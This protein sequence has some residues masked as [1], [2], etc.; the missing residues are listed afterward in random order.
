MRL[1]LVEDDELIAE[2]LVNALSDQRYVVDV[3][4][5]GQEGREL[6]EIFA[7]DLLLLDVMLPKL[8]GITLCQQLRSQGNRIPII[9]LTALD[10]STDKVMGLDAGADDYVV[11]P[12]DL[13]ELLARIRALLRR[14]SS[15]LPPV[16]EW[17]NLHLDPSN[18]EVTY[19]GR[20]LNL[21]PKEYS[22]L[23]LF[24]RN[25]RRVYSQSAILEQLWSYEEL[26]EE[27]TVRAHIKGLRQKLKAVGAPADLIE[28]VY[29]LG[30][31]LKLPSSSETTPVSATE[32]SRTQQQ[33]MVEVQK[34]WERCVLKFSNRVAVLEQATTALLQGT[35]ADELRHKA[36][37]EAHKLAGSLGMFGF[38]GSRLAREIEQM[39]QARM[40][41]GQDQAL[42]MSEL[43]VALRRDLQRT[44]STPVF[45]PGSVDERKKLLVVDD[46]RSCAELLLMEAD[47]LGMRVY[48]A[49]D[50]SQARD[51][52]N[53]DRPHVV[54]LKLSSFGSIEDS[55]KLLAELNTCTP[56]VP[57]VVLTAQDSL[58]NRVK[59]ARLGGRG[60]LHKSLPP[61]QL[62]EAVIQVLKR[63]HTESAKVMAVDDDPQVLVTLVN[64]L[65]PWGL[66]VRTLDDPRRFWETL[67]ESAPDLLVLDVEMAHLSGIELCQ[68]VRNDPRWSRLPVLFLSVHTDADT[69]NR[70][71]A[72]GADD[73]VV[74]PIVG[75]ELV[76]RIFNRLERSRLLRNMAEVDALTGV[77]NRRKL[78]QDVNQFLRLAD[79]HCQPLCLAI[80][81]LDHFKQVNNQYGHA[82][83]DQVLCRFG[84]LLR[85]AF[86]SEDVVGRWGG[87]EFVVGMYG[88]TRSE[89]VERSL[90][91]LET[92]RQEEFTSANGTKFQVTFSAG[93][94]QYPQ[95]GADLQAL[96]RA[97][98]ALVDQAKAAGR[99]RVLA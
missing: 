19:E 98:L 97:A 41:L 61:D 76:T 95:D 63:T 34:V 13:Q 37:Q 91:V 59:V 94:A 64:L 86:R 24:I 15:T 96:Y 9:L 88:M 8:N 3:A 81:D 46:D 66:K 10:A 5:D 56:P 23:E 62:L 12:F 42:Q 45:E 92:L 27:D 35:L 32:A 53:C 1:L 31:R 69:L 21:T 49:T 6:V 39:F 99:N 29:G 44:T 68:V 60:F 43:V 14:G 36:R 18:Y 47:T 22:L 26:P 57:V 70:V 20:L 80:L 30:Y 89:G 50:L 28:T 11:K 4:Y 79:N 73:Y 33:T 93:V 38:E 51:A 54:L 74:K 71:F 75:P 2:A 48:V 58:I 83:G 7:Y 40:P 25:S 16:L 55:L 72:A 87:T 78:T 65:E 17:R 67:E 84:Q 90:E 52:I 77:F 85:Q 82:V